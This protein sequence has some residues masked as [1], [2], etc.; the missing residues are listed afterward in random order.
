PRNKDRS[1][2]AQESHHEE[3]GTRDHGGMSMKFHERDDNGLL[4]VFALIMLGTGVAV[5][6][7]IALI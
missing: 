2:Q 7:L 3:H 6:K 5:G 4:A 1:L